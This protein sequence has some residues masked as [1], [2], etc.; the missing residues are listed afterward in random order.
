MAEETK[1]NP[2]PV[3]KNDVKLYVVSDNHAVSSFGPGTE[4][5]EAQLWP[6]KKPD[7]YA[8][9]LARLLELEAIKPKA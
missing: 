5:T 8:K 1:K 3:V 6:G 2:D 7:E 4:L 9:D